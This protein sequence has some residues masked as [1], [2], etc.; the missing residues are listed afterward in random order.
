MRGFLHTG[1]LLDGMDNMGLGS[2]AAKVSAAAVFDVLP[3]RGGIGGKE[4]GRA[5]QESRRTEPALQRVSL[6][7]GLLQ[8]GQLAVFGEALNGGDLAALGVDCQL[9]AGIDGLTI[10][11]NGTG[12]AAGP[13]TSDLGPR[14]F[15]MVAQGVGQGDPRLKQEFKVLAVHLQ[16]DGNGPGSKG[17]LLPGGLHLAGR[18]IGKRGRRGDR[19]RSQGLDKGST[20]EAGSDRFFPWFHKRSMLRSC[21]E[22]PWEAFPERRGS[23]QVRVSL[24]FEKQSTH[25]EQSWHQT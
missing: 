17:R 11:E 3:R 21:R 14:Q 10:K 8:G 4:G 5:E 6:D 23:G 12:S 18:N 7:K 9:H 2:A 20:G 16:G 19:G 13:V 15:G 24:A 25:F 1:C 22:R